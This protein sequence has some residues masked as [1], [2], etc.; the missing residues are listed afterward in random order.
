MARQ[1]IDKTD[2]KILRLLTDNARMPFLEVARE[3]KVSGAAIHQRIQKLLNAGVIK[4]FQC[5][6]DP[7]VMGYE[8]C[9]YIG[10]FLKD[11]SNIDE[12]VQKLYDM[13]EVVECHFTTGRYDLLIKVHTTTNDAL[14]ELIR[15]QLLPLG[16]GRTETIISFKEN[17]KRQISVR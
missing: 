16:L 13:P 4:G 15:Q 11:S 7:Q 8:T 9:A 14:L 1:L 2:L 5:V 6:V 3:C 17:L 12:I 10:V